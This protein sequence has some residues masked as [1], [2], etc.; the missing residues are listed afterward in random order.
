[1]KEPGRGS[2]LSRLRRAGLCALVAGT[3][4]VTYAVQSQAASHAHL[5]GSSTGQPPVTESAAAAS[6]QLRPSAS[7]L[8][9]AQAAAGSGQLLANLAAPLR[10]HEVFGFAPSWTLGQQ[11]SFDVSRLSTIAYF[12]VDVTADGSLSTTGAGWSALQGSDLAR[13][14]TRAHQAKTRVVLVAKTFDPATLHSLASEPTAVKRLGSQLA[15]VLS[16]KGLDGV[17]LDFEGPGNGDRV[18]FT[19]FIRGLAYQLHQ[20]DRGWQVSVDTFAS[21]AMDSAGLIDVPALAT[22]VDAFFVMTYDM[23]SSGTPAPTAPLRGPGW[24]DTRAMFSYLSVVPGA[25]VILGIPFYAYAWPT[26]NGAPGA[27]TVGPARAMTYAQLA[28]AGGQVS[29]AAAQGVVWTAFRDR[30]GQWW[31]AYFDDPQSVGLK[32]RLA[33]QLGLAGVGVWALGM[34]GGDPAMMS[35][36]LGQASPVK[37]PAR[38]GCLAAAA[39]PN[40]HGCP[41]GAGVEATGRSHRSRCRGV[42][43]AATAPNAN[44]RCGVEPCSHSQPAS[45]ARS[46]ARVVSSRIAHA[47]PRSAFPGHAYTNPD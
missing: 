46:D 2:A 18:G 47:G 41:C 14:V 9:A 3:Q 21:A 43:A 23:N 44:P 35:A 38:A 39:A 22:S 25:K 34:D 11:A 28:V 12:G 31:Q 45:S 32:A 19:T 29:W 6:P 40:A 1:M 16:A 5:V 27:A 20:V 42:A 8:P 17:N 24:N 26:A 7:S 10:P 4:M 33:N 37:R 30:S 36:L 13:L 15:D